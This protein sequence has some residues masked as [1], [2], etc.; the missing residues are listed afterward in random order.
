[1]V[2]RDPSDDP[3][4]ELVRRL[5]YFRRGVRVHGGSLI[6]GIVD[7][8]IRIIVLPDGDRDDSH[9]SFRNGGVVEWPSC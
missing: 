2:R 1:M 7:D 6:C 5:L 3:D 9:V 8:E 4:T